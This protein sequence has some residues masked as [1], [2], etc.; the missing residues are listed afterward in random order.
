MRLLGGAIEYTGA[1]SNTDYGCSDDAIEGNLIGINF[2]SSGNP[3]AGLGNG[4]SLYPVVSEEA[5]I[6]VSDPTDPNQTSSGN[7]IGGTAAGAAN[8]ISGNAGGGIL[9]S[10]GD[11]TGNLVVGNFIGTDQNGTVV[12]NTGDGVQITG[13]ATN[14]TIG[15]VTAMP[16][17][18][19]GNV[20]SGNT[21]SGIA[22]GSAGTPGNVIEG[23]LVGTV[24]SGQNGAGND[25]SGVV[26]YGMGTTISDCTIAG[27]TVASGPGGGGIAN[28]GTLTVTDSTI[29]D[30]SF[31]GCCVPF[32]G[33]GVFNSGTLTITESAISENSSAIGGGIY[34]DGAL[35]AEECTFETNGAT[36]FGGAIDSEVGHMDVVDCSFT[37]NTAGG[38]AGA[39]SDTG[40]GS[41]SGCTIRDNS[42]GPAGGGG[43]GVWVGVLTIANSTIADNS[44]LSG[45]GGGIVVYDGGTVKVDNDTIAD[46]GASIGG[47]IAIEP[48]CTVNIG[49][50]IVADNNA[51]SSS[52]DVAGSFAS[53]GYNLIG[54]TDGSTGWVSSDL[55]G[56]VQQPLD[57]LLSPLGNYGGPT[58][59][60]GLLAGSPALGAGSVALAVDPTTSQPLTYDQRGPGYPRTL[61]GTV[62]IGAVEFAPLQACT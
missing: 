49:N 34:N 21:G 29:T 5:G 46:N 40:T 41:I 19:A 2:D 3:I 7:T 6:F 22:I 54:K 14:N 4:G 53:E 43:I 42:A 60:I 47:G 55:T 9:F 58:E 12:A 28:Y 18:G 23:D 15:G 50:T 37:G 13:G 38:T 11:V 57:P 61:N 39:V 45:P 52:P 44:A 10:G 33:G 31:V 26:N 17:A 51:S 24:S 56:T 27:N 30:N 16:G 8:V 62:D 25:S 32:T 20:I 48:G 36:A 59:T 1:A 35:I